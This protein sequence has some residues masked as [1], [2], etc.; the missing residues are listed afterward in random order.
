MKSKAPLPVHGADL[1]ARGG[2][3]VEGG[4]VRVRIWSVK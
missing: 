4:G 1:V 3:D 2:G